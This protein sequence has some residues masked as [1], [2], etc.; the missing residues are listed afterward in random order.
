MAFPFLAIAKLLPFLSAVP[1]VVNALKSGNPTE[2]VGKVA[3]VA[4]R[5]A[6]VKDPE[7]AAERII[8]DPALQLELQKTLANER[9]EYARLAVREQELDVEQVKSVNATMQSEAQ[10]KGEHWFR[11]GWRPYNGYIV[12]TASL[13]TVC[14]VLYLS[15]QAIVTK[16]LSTLNAIPVIVTAIAT[17]LAIPGAAVGITAWT[18]GRE[19]IEQFKK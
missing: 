12:G 7:T 19:K 2:A 15:Y 18:R 10:M 11:W 9:L 16:D 1:E 14:G 3:D 13:I 17:V 8:N 6:G 4:M 5:V